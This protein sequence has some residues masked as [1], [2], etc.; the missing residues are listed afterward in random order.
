MLEVVTSDRE[1]AERVRRL[2]VS[3]VGARH[4]LERLDAGDQGSG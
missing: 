4:L 2:G 3:V 1:L